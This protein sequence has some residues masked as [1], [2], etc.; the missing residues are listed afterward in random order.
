MTQTVIKGS[1]EHRELQ[2]C[3]AKADLVELCLGKNI[4]PIP[5]PTRS[6]ET[7]QY[8]TSIQPANYVF[9]IEEGWEVGDGVSM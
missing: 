2:K 3:M 1:P 4:L 5:T 7:G 8:T 9:V 6:A